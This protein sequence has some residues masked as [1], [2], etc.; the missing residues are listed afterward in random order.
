MTNFQPKFEIFHHR[1]PT[2]VQLKVRLARLTMGGAASGAGGWRVSKQIVTVQAEALDASTI[3]FSQAVSV[4]AAGDAKRGE[5]GVLVVGVGE[6][7]L[8][9]TISPS[10]ASPTW[11]ED[12]Q[13]LRA[14]LTDAYEEAV[15]G[16]MRATAAFGDAPGTRSSQ[17]VETETLVAT[18]ATV[19]KV[20][21]PAWRRMLTVKRA[22]LASVLL[23]GGGLVAYG[24]IA[25]SRQPDAFVASGDAA[26]MDK[27][28]R[29]TI[30]A[31]LRKPVGD[32]GML[33]GQ[34]VALE[35]MR[36]MGLEPGKANTGCLV[37]VH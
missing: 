25:G 14:A 10:E 27:R 17:A 6:P 21:K 26:E 2:G 34:S 32:T 18:V 35:T 22:V 29:D 12:V 16:E 5:L 11:D 20:R 33:Q 36:A 31:S 23:V 28:V 15:F 24:W 7:Q 8:V 30:A 13:A 19:A 9:A 3:E 4:S 37:G 1:T